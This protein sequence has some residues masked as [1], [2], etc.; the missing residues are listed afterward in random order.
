MALCLA[1]CTVYNDKDSGTGPEVT[2]NDYIC[3][4][5]VTPLCRIIELTDFFNNYR[6]LDDE[7][8]LDSLGAMIF[9]DYFS[10]ET[11]GTDSFEQEYWGKIVTTDVEGEYVA[12]LSSY[13]TGVEAV[14]SAKVLSDGSYSFVY[15]A[16]NNDETSDDYEVTTE[17]VVN[18]TDGLYEVESLEI[19]YSDN[20]SEK[21]IELTVDSGSGSEGL[22]IEPCSEGSYA[23]YPVDG[24]LYYAVTGYVTLDFKVAF[25]G[26]HFEI[27]DGTD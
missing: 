21:P 1:A 27:L 17:A 13:W 18:V 26:S 24:A 3:N 19:V 14:Y 16:S 8:K 22:I 5:C 11:F 15:D 23:V 10:A 9:G 12:T 4:R 2:I 7:Q 20:D 25:Y 6:G